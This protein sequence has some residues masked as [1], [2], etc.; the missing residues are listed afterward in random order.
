MARVSQIASLFLLSYFLIVSF[1]NEDE[2]LITT[3]DGQVQGKF[4]PVVN[5]SV[6][7]FL[8]IPFAKPPVGNLR[9]RVPEPV[10]PWQGVKDATNYANTCF[11]LVDTTFPG[12]IC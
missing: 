9:F 5:G 2:L 6:R 10:Q 12:R 11:Q 4:L 1:A 7:A 8:G 3:K